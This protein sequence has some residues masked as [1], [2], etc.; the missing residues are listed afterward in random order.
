MFDH[1]VEGLQRKGPSCQSC[2]PVS[3]DHE[4]FEYSMICHNCELVSQQ[5]HFKVLDCIDNSQ[6]FLLCGSIPDFPRNEFPGVVRQGPL[7]TF[8]VPLAECCPNTSSGCISLQDKLLLRVSQTTPSPE[9]ACA[10]NAVWCSGAHSIFSEA[11]FLVAS[12]F[13]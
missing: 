9:R 13:R 8:L 6:T 11:F 4:I 2:S 7:H 10:T 1:V 5:V 12:G 3:H